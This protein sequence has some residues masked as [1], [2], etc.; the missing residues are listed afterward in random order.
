[1]LGL[2][3]L[4]SYF[5]AKLNFM[6]TF[7][8]L[9]LFII[10]CLTIGYRIHLSN[11]FDRNCKAYIYRTSE[12]N[13]VELAT[14]E[15]TIVINYLEK[16]NLTSGYTSIFVNDPAEDIGFWYTNLKE[17][18]NELQ[19][20]NSDSALEKSN[21]LLKL[22]ETLLSEKGKANI[23]KGLNVYPHNLAWGI[24][25]LLAFFAAIVGLFLMIP[26]SSW[27]EK[28]INS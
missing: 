20:L 26:A 23:P 3:Y 16:N 10:A 2:L 1:M 25:I 28:N 18:L 22:R 6:K 17:S 24:A 19:S 14:Q 27:K 7:F 8:G 4:I 5:S 11:S 9:T 13:T 21:V 15:L 12:A